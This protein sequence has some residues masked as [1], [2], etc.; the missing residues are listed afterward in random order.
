[1]KHSGV[2]ILEATAGI[3]GNFTEDNI[4]NNITEVED[5]YICD[6]IYNPETLGYDPYYC[7]DYYTE[8][9]LG[10]IINTANARFQ[11]MNIA[12]EGTINV[13]GVWDA[14]NEIYANEDD[15]DFDWGKADSLMVIAF[16]DNIDIKLM[17]ADTKQTIA[18]VEAYLYSED[19]NVGG[20]T[21]TEKYM[22]MRFVFPD[23][24]KVDAETYFN[25]GFEDFVDEL[26]IF[27]D[28]LNAKYDAGLEHVEYETSDS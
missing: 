9:D 8:V 15:Y 13:K 14:N 21:W 11:I 20:E 16:N 28:D 19:Y 18:T 3:M 1:M 2:I 5:Q 26:N 6:W 4:N 22:D 27:I 25:E 23:N 24:S 7:S 12:V 17:Y 10:N